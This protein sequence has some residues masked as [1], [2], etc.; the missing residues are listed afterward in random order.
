MWGGE[1]TQKSFSSQSIN[2]NWQI[3]SYRNMLRWFP[4]RQA[5]QVSF[6]WTQGKRQVADWS[7]LGSTVREAVGSCFKLQFFCL[8]RASVTGLL[9]PSHLHTE[10]ANPLKARLQGWAIPL[11][12]H[13]QLQLPPQ[14][15]CLTWRIQVGE[16]AQ[17]STEGQ[18][19]AGNRRTKI[20]LF[21]TILRD[22]VQLRIR[23]IFKTF[24]K[25]RGTACCNEPKQIFIQTLQGTLCVS[26][27]LG[28]GDLTVRKVMAI[29]SH[30]DTKGKLIG[31]I[32]VSLT[33]K[34]GKSKLPV[35]SHFHYRIKIHILKLNMHGFLFAIYVK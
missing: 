28:G 8:L 26:R 32:G 24:G 2:T 34:K 20:S 22:C 25:N 18:A 13:C 3:S 16:E 31:T 33:I 29:W 15:H 35:Y 11:P 30:T 21:S 17:E 14:P 7:H 4:N 12:Q 10:E 27:E 1:W 23:W 5:S 19:E 6:S 9:K